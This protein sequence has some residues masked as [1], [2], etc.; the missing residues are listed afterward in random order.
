[1]VQDHKSR[2]KIS[3]KQPVLRCIT[4]DFLGCPQDR[5]PSKLPVQKKNDQSW[6]GG[7]AQF[8]DLGKF[9]P[10]KVYKF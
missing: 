6:K 1:M 2:A 3:K 9:L 7:Q 8:E 10:P 5:L 4:F